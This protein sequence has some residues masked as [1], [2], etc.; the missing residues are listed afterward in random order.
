[1]KSNYIKKVSGF[2]LML[3][4]LI[5]APGLLDTKAFAQELGPKAF[6]QEDDHCNDD[7]YSRPGYGNYNR[8]EIQRIGGLSGY[9]EGYQHG[10][11]DRFDGE[12]FNFWHDQTY[13]NPGSGRFSDYR[14]RGIYQQ[15]FRSGYERGYRDAYYGRPYRPAFTRYQDQYDNHH[16]RSYNDQYDDNQDQ[17]YNNWNYWRNR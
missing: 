15:A 6:A 17:T 10:R 4:M 16:D 12:T 8:F 2:I 5:A 1:M 3:G 14:F 11:E 7:Y 9:R 13:R